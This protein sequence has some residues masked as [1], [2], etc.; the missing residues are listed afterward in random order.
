M[1]YRLRVIIKSALK[2]F[3]STYCRKQ[4]L[5]FVTALPHRGCCVLGKGCHLSL[6][7][8]PTQTIPSTQDSPHPSGFP[9]CQESPV[10]E[11]MSL[12]G[13]LLNPDEDIRIRTMRFVPRSG[14][15]Q[16]AQTVFLT[17]RSCLVLSS[18]EQSQRP[19]TQA[20]V[21][22][23]PISQLA[24]AVTIFNDCSKNLFFF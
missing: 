15:Q 11:Q 14:N 2:E 22:K 23:P 3:F 6:I 20:Y 5:L 4:A 16:N 10:W 13:W 21:G 8:P 17:Y 9:L 18:E 1:L 19:L 12:S 24:K 7:L